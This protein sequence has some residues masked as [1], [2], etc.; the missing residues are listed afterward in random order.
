MSLL[1]PMLAQS[2]PLEHVL[3]HPLSDG[4][5][6]GFG[7]EVVVNNHMVMAT[8]A[9]VLMLVIFAWVA[10]KMKPRGTDTEAY[11]TK[12]RVTQTFEVIL[13]FLRDE[14][15]RPALGDLTDKYIGYVWTTF[16]FVLFCNVLG[17]VP[18]GEMLGLFHLGSPRLG[19]LGGTATGNIN[20]TAVLALISL[21]MIFFVGIRE[22]GLAYFSHFAPVPIWPIMKDSS[23][24]MLPIALLLVVLEVV[25]AAVKPF[26]LC[27]RLFANMLA[28]HMVIASLI[29]L[30]FLAADGLGALA[31]GVSVPVLAGSLFICLLELFVAFLQAYIFAFLT[32]LFI[33]QGAVHE[34]HGHGEADPQS[35]SH[36]HADSYGPRVGLPGDS[37][38]AGL[39]H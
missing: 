9:A 5:L 21:F 32:V 3:S 25:G 8:I 18:L 28:G 23:P 11:V 7:F 34:E 6:R 31:Y 13:V 27:M 14:M 19:H 39:T 2:S 37:I 22:R 10:G 17:L 12:G 26:A 20:V 16:F 36:G 15:T 4:P 29:G 1:L 33:A 38:T 35:L 30:I 24:G